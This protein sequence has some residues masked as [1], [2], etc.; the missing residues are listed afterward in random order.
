MNANDMRKPSE[1]NWAQVDAL[2][3]E[4][5]DTTDI[6]PLRETFLSKATLR[7]PRDLVPVTV[8]LDPEVLAWFKAQGGDWEQRL[9]AALR[10]YAKSHRVYG[11]AS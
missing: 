8:R 4:T 9:N 5:I 1:T 10:I 11:K 3:D 7:L 2:T 6:A